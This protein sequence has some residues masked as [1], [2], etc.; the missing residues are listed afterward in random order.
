[1]T[2]GNNLMLKS[3]LQSTSTKSD[4]STMHGELRDVV[5]ISTHKCNMNITL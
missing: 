4:V 5:S 2:T 1:M 3:V